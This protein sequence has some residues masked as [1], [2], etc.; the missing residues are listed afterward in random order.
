MFALLFV[1]VMLPGQLSGSVGGACHS[2]PWGHE[3]NPHVRGRDDLK[4]KHFLKMLLFFL[5][6]NIK[7]IKNMK[8]SDNKKIEMAF[9]IS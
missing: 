2:R 7:I 1:S 5:A 3:F 4:I 8:V 9:F 6:R